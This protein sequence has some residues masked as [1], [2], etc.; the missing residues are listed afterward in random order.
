MRKRRTW[1]RK[2]NE[3]SD[4]SLRVLYVGGEGGKHRTWVGSRRA[5]EREGAG[6]DGEGECGRVAAPAVVP[7]PS[8]WSSKTNT[9]EYY[10]RTVTETAPTAAGEAAA[11]APSA[12][13]PAR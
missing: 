2:G 13:S 4:L 11:A 6:S 9:V 12:P 10:S 5:E 8:Q 1:P 3:I 7:R